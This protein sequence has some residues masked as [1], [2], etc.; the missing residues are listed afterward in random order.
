MDD[1]QIREATLTDLPVLLKFQQGVV[2]YERPYDPTIAPDPVSYYDLKDLI[3]DSEVVVLVAVSENRL[4]G[5]GLGMEKEGRR[6]LNH[7]TYAYLGLMY[8]D[9]DFRGMG[10]NAKII[11]ALKQWALSKGLYEM[12]L[13]VYSDNISAIK[14]YEKTGFKKHIIEMRLA[15]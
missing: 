7:K 15:E 2:D 6:Y 11:E 3:L 8:T 13:T 12:R 4:I 10:V 1:I 5:C 14:A 9:P